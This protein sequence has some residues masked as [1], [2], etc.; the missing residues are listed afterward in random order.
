MAGFDCSGF[1]IEILQAAGKLP[2]KFD[3][4]ASGLFGM[5]PRSAIGAPGCLVFWH[6]S[7]KSSIV[8]VE[9]CIGDGLAIGASGGGSR[10]QTGQDAINQNAFIKIRPI[11]SRPGVAGYVDPFS[12]QQ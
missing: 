11:D 9:Y 2:R 1:C 4:T 8:H 10:T 3:T 7:S 12:A 5:F 6:G